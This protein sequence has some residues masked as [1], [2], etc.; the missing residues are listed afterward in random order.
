MDRATR[1]SLNSPAEAAVPSEPA[2]SQVQ[3]FEA[4]ARS[5]GSSPRRF[6]NAQ[7]DEANETK[8]LAAATMPVLLPIPAAVGFA[9]VGVAAAAGLVDYRARLRR[10]SEVSVRPRPR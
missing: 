3:S 5:S 10:V 2:E 1:T 4:C 9:G 7:T 8:T 6:A